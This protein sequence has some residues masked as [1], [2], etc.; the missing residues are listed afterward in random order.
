MRK[1]RLATLKLAD[2]LRFACGID[3]S[4]CSMENYVRTLG[5]RVKEEPGIDLFYDS[6]VRKTGKKS[7]VLLL[8][9]HMP[10]KEQT[11]AQASELGHL[12][13]HMG[14]LIDEKQWEKQPCGKAGPCQI[15][16]ASRRLSSRWPFSFQGKSSKRRFL[17]HQTKTLQT[18]LKSQSISMYLSLLP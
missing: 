15:P 2:V 9:P 11:F 4:M 1:R 12:F 17:T 16:C 7:F 8:P 18:F 3:E 6:G 13:L 10:E 5:G 14:Y